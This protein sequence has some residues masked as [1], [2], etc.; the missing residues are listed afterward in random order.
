LGTPFCLFCLFG[1]ITLFV[2]AYLRLTYQLSI[3]L[4]L[5]HCTYASRYTQISI[6]THTRALLL[7]R[8]LFVR[9][10][11]LGRICPHS[12]PPRCAR[13]KCGY[14]E[15]SPRRHVV[16]S[17]C[18]RPIPISGFRLP[19]RFPVF[20]WLGCEQTEREALGTGWT[21]T[22]QECVCALHESVARSGNP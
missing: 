4:S 20:S 13:Q 11:G 14:V 18:H 17:V 5:P 9:S 12:Q 21:A 8:H 2:P 7:A 10:F 3:R 1:L 19:I 16:H 15:T 22:K 6:Y